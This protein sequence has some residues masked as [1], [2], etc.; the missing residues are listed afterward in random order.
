MR[1]VRSVA[2]DKYVTP[3][4]WSSWLALYPDASE[5]LSRQ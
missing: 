3:Q 2:D 1:S 4:E 5:T